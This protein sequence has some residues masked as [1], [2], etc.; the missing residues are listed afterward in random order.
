VGFLVQEAG[1]SAPFTSLFDSWIK[2]MWSVG[3]RDPD[4][5]FL[6]LLGICWSF[7]CPP[8]GASGVCEG[9]R[10]EGWVQ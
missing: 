7:D 4:D 5:P 8:R 6:S 2:S 3:G 10:M 9:G 1:S